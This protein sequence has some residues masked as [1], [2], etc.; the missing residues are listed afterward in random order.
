VWRSDLWI[1]LY[2]LSEAKLTLGDTTAARGLCAEGLTIIRALAVSH[3]ADVQ[4]R[5]QL[6]MTL[7]LLASMQGGSEREQALNEALAILEKLHATND[8]PS[9]KIGWLDHIR[10]EL[11]AN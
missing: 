7:H 6:V 5:L 10:Q 3:P 11:L 4:R 1:A 8:L 9:D 2:K